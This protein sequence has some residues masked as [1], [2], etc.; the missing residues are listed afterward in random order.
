[1]VVENLSWVGGKKVIF[2]QEVKFWTCFL[3]RHGGVLNKFWISFEQGV[4]LV[5]FCN[6]LFFFKITGF[7]IMNPFAEFMLIIT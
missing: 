5:K 1:M 2:E 7:Y 4:C 6:F 3:Y